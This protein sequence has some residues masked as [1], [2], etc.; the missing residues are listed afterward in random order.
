VTSAVSAASS[1]VVL[2]TSLRAIPVPFRLPRPLIA[3]GPL[4]RG[5]VSQTPELAQALVVGARV[6]DLEPL[7]GNVVAAV[8]FGFERHWVFIIIKGLPFYAGSLMAPIARARQQRPIRGRQLQTTKNTVPIIPVRL[9][10]VLVLFTL[11]L[12]LGPR[13][14]PRPT[15][16]DGYGARCGT[17]AR[18]RM[19][20]A[21]VAGV[22][23]NPAL[24][25]RTG[26]LAVFCR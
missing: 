15:R 16:F 14:S 10:K 8:R 7:L 3:D 17:T 2:G 6:H 13:C 23:C 9:L 4:L 21:W 20:V 24:A 18:F 12:Q 1:S 11:E 22:P 26:L 19:L 25:N 5:Q